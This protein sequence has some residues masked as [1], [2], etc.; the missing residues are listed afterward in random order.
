MPQVPPSSRE[1]ILS[2]AEALFA[3][4]GYTGVGIST[5]AEASGLG[6]SSLFHHFPSKASL[7]CAV[8]LGVLARIESRVLP[9]LEKSGTSEQKLGN[10]VDALIDALAEH[11]TSARL[12][13]REVFEE[14]DP[15]LSA[16]PEAA[17][18]DAR[19]AGMIDGVAAILEAG[20]ASGQ[21]RKVG[22]PD[23]LQTI[24]GA[25]VYHF[26]SGDFGEK[27]LGAS[28]FS[29]AAVARRKREV[30]TL[31]SNGLMPE[32]RRSVAEES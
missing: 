23:L 8:L 21:F 32:A 18:I 10:V 25:T 3:R 28:L 19:L 29:A 20:V 30:K 17:E 13:L 11:P 6:K 12:L 24:I 27:L 26:A 22:I 9:A 15:A 31:L 4:R 7:Y 5:V 16:A 1:K 14:P 2:V